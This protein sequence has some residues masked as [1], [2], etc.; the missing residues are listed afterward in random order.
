[1][2][3]YSDLQVEPSTRRLYSKGEVCIGDNVWIGDN[4]IILPDVKIGNG[5]VIGAGTVVT[6]SFSDMSII[7]GNPAK[8]INTNN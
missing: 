3:S 5:C 8:K 4:V 2:T 1:M 7:V 6:H